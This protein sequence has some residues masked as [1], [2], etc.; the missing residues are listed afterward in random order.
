MKRTRI[1]VV[2]SFVVAFA[3]GLVLGAALGHT[4]APPPSR[5]FLGDQLKLTPDQQQKMGE[6]W[7]ST[8]QNWFRTYG[9]RRHALQAQRDQLIGEMLTP[10]QQMQH[11]VIIQ[12]YEKGVSELAQEG[13]KAREEAKK[14][15]ME[16]LTESQRKQ[17]EEILR[18]GEEHGWGPPGRGPNRNPPPS[19]GAAGH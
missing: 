10:V 16:L 14:R 7:S 17:F 4:A 1:L 9:E 18:Q 2:V 6:I 5:P 19:L 3:A 13:G 15:T 12:E 8:M 11:D